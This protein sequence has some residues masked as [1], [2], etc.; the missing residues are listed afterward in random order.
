MLGDFM[1][2][3]F[4]RLIAYIIDTLLISLIALLLA[5]STQINFQ[6]DNYTWGL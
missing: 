1:N 4:K 5:N 2:K 6:L 3:G